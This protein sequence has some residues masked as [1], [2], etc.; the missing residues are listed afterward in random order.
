MPIGRRPI[1][2]VFDYI[3]GF[4]SVG[5]IT[6]FVH[7]DDPV[8][9]LPGIPARSQLLLPTPFGEL[10]AEVFANNNAIPRPCIFTRRILVVGSR[11]RWPPGSSTLQCTGRADRPAGWWVSIR[12]MRINIMSPQDIRVVILQ[13]NTHSLAHLNRPE[14]LPGQLPRGYNDDARRAF[15]PGVV[16]LD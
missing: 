8:Y 2:K 6:I 9:P 16:A 14:Y 7:F 15:P 5:S 4:P 11:W 13:N 1:S 12:R 10:P 3:G